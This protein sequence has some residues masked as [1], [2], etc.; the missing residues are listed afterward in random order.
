MY[1][2]IKFYCQKALSKGCEARQADSLSNG[3][4]RTSLLHAQ[5]RRR[6]RTDG[7]I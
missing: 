1:S 4:G 2:M 7:R 3:L 5:R 6:Y